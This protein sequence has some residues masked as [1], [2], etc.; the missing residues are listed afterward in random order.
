M[1]LLRA[2]HC[3]PVKG[4]KQ[5]QISACRACCDVHMTPYEIEGQANE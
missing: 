5:V 1:V 3:E 4:T 2:V